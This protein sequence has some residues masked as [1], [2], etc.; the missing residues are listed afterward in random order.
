MNT[1]L[2]LASRR[3]RRTPQLITRPDRPRVERLSRQTLKKALLQG[4]PLIIVERGC[5]HLPG[6][7]EALEWLHRLPPESP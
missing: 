5:I 2:Q 6:R 7:T 4:E 3:S 1:A